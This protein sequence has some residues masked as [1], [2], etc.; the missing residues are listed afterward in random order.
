MSA[1]KS[2]FVEERRERIYDIISQNKRV[3]TIELSEALNC[4]EAII[5]RDLA[6]MEAMGRIHRTYGGAML[7]GGTLLEEHMQIRENTHRDEKLKIAQ[8]I[9]QYVR[10]GDALMLDGG[11]TM[12]LL[13]RCLKPLSSL[14]ILTN[15]PDVGDQLVGLNNNR[16]ILTGGELMPQTKVLVG[17][18]A[19]KTIRSF[20]ADRAILGMSSMLVDTGFFTVNQYEAEVKMAMIESAKEVIIAMDSSKIGLVTFSFVCGFSSIQRLVTDKNIKREHHKAL[21]DRNVIVE[22]CD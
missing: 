20:R 2:I 5:R 16:V 15:A 19:I 21:V 12:N 8:H 17:P 22:I 7:P 14:T 3:T 9:T 13:A 4:S 10:P 18:T 6:A 11:S 1:N